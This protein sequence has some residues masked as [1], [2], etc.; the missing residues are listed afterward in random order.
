[1]VYYLLVG[2]NH[3]SIVEAT[4]HVAEYINEEALILHLYEVHSLCLVDSPG[5]H[6]NQDEDYHYCDV[7][8]EIPRKI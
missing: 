7:E 1:V 8:L 3:E 6:V 4:D 5:E 2:C